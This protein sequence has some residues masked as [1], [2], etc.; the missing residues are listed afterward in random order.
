MVKSPRID[1]GVLLAAGLELMKQH[2]KPLTKKPRAGS[3]KLYTLPNGDVVRVRTCND[4]K[5]I[6]VTDSPSP[7]DAKLNIKGTDEKAHWLLSVMP[8][9]ARTPGKV[10]AYFVPTEVAV[11]GTRKHQRDWLLSLPKTAGDNK[12]WVLYFGEK[13]PAE[14]TDFQEEWSRYLLSGDVLVGPTGTLV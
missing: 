9:V 8:V 10:I 13:R 6:V 4:H 1:T 3:A 12:T 14:V 7:E 2:G 5:L 11:A